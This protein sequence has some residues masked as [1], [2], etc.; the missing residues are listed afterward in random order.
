MKEAGIFDGLSPL[1][2][3]THLEIQILTCSA[4]FIPAGAGNT[5]PCPV[6]ISAAAVYPR[7]RGEH[8]C[9]VFA[10]FAA[11][12]L[13][14]LARGTPYACADNTSGSRF[15]PAG[16]GN[17]NAVRAGSGVTSVYP[18]WR[19]EHHDKIPCTT[20]P[21]GLS[22]LARG[23]L[24]N[25]AFE[26]GYIR[27]IPAGAGNT[28][29]LTGTDDPQSV[30]PRWRGE[31]CGNKGL[32][33]FLTGL[34]PLA[35]G[36]RDVWMTTRSEYRFIPAGAGNTS[37]KKP[38]CVLLSVYPRWRG[39]HDQLAA[40][41]RCSYGL[42]PLA[43]GT[44]FLSPNFRLFLRFIPAGAGNTLPPA[45]S[46]RSASVYPRWRGEHAVI[47]KG[48]NFPSGLSPLARGTL[49]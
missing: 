22:P 19:G 26:K 48:K 9:T 28:C 10:P 16:A 20:S 3:G 13:S 29:L 30:Y 27:F 2:R 4:R 47:Q 39:E 24:Q 18:R 14:P 32:I 42:S 12:G 44:L 25:T 15:I 38:R 8:L 34:S 23:T 43:R 36:T 46:H 41:H 37:R 11:F 6:S 21:I 49:A 7:W 35:R 40:A 31:H 45:Q 33:N 5:C 1:A 17:T